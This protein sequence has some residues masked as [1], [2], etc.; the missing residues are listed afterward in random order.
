MIHRRP[1]RRVPLSLGRVT[2]DGLLQCGYHGWYFEGKTGRVSRIPNLLD[3]QRFPPIYR[4]QSYG[5]CESSGFVRIC[6][7]DRSAGR[8]PSS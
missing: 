5:V 7:A 4:A 1:H 3:K 8:L 6:G 2:A